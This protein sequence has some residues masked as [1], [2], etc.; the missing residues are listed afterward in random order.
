M[1]YLHQAQ[2]IYYLFNKIKNN[3]TIDIVLLINYTKISG[4]QIS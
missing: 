1:Q 4:Y 2:L 3:E